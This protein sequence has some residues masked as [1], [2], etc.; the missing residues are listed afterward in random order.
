MSIYRLFEI[1]GGETGWAWH[2][3]YEFCQKAKWYL[4]ARY[5]DE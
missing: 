1:L 5:Y 2:L 3:P 4:L